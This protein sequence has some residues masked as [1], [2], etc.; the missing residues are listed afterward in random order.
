MGAHR[1]GQDQQP[2]LPAE[3]GGADHLHLRQGRARRPIRPRVG[4]IQGGETR[5]DINEPE[6]CRVDAHSPRIRPERASFQNACP[7]LCREPLRSSRYVR[8]LA[9]PS[10]PE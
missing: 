4:A 7:L 1:G 3:V 5:S 2:H 6:L 8:R 10:V 9:W